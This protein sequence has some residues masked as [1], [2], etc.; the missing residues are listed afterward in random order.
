MFSQAIRAE[1]SAVRLLFKNRVTLLLLVVMYGALLF[2]GY[3]FVSTREATI[4]T[5]GRDARG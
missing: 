5:V 4:F 2:A 3:L 1:V